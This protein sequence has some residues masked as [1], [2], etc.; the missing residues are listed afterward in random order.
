MDAEQIVL[1]E[2]AVPGSKNGIVTVRSAIKHRQAAQ[3]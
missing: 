3:A 1:I 2:G